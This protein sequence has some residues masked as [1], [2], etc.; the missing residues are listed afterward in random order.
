MMFWNKKNR[1]DDPKKNIEKERFV[2]LFIG[3]LIGQLAYGFGL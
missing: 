3:C 2:G 1:Q